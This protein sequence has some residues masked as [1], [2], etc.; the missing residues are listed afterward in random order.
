MCV[1]AEVDEVE[2]AALGDD[3]GQV[4]E[5]VGLPLPAAVR[6]DL[7]ERSRSKKRSGAPEPAQSA[8][9]GTGGAGVQCSLV[10]SERTSAQHPAPAASS[11]IQISGVSAMYT[12]SARRRPRATRR[13][14]LHHRVAG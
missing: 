13:S 1:S 8:A 11:P 14:A 7:P 12:G 6:D 10:R 5:I 9:S 2:R 3:E 4:P